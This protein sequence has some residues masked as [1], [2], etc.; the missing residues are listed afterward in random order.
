MQ[1][2]PK[3]NAIASCAGLNILYGSVGEWWTLALMKVLDLTD[4][5]ESGLSVQEATALHHID[6]IRHALSFIHSTRNTFCSKL[7]SLPDEVLMHISR[8]CA[9]QADSQSPRYLFERVV[10]TFI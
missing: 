9:W 6:C 3:T 5:Q 1:G 8:E 4:D 2:K 10:L 7:L